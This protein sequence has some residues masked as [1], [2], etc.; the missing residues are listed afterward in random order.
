MTNYTLTVLD[1]SGIQNYLFGTNNLKQNAGASY[2]AD[3][4][5]RDWVKEVLDDVTNGAHNVRGFE[6]VDKPFDESKTI[7]QEGVQAEV[8]YAGGG[9]TVLLFKQVGEAKAFATKLSRKVILEAPDLNL[10]IAHYQD[11]DWESRA[12][13]GDNG[14][15]QSVMN[16]L[17]KRKQEY[18]PPQPLRGLGVTVDGA[19]TNRPAVG[20]DLQNRPVAAESWAKQQAE[21]AAEERLLQFL[22]NSI[23]RKKYSIA[24]D[25]EDIGGS[26]ED[27]SYIAVVHADGN[28]MGKR[29]RAIQ[30]KFPHASQNADYVRAMRVFSLSV[31]G[32]AHTALNTTVD[33]LVGQIDKDFTIGGKIELKKDKDSKPILPFRPIVFGG[34]DVTFICEGRLGLQL[35]AYYLEK[36]TEQLLTDGDEEYGYAYCRAGVAVT[37][38]HYPFALAYELAESLCASAKVAIRRWQEE[39]RKPKEG[40][41]VID[42]HFAING[43]NLGLRE[44]R[45]RDYTS[46][47]KRKST[48]GTSDLLMRPLW[49]EKSPALRLGWHSWEQ[50]ESIL[51]EFQSNWL[52]QRSKLIGLRE[53]LRRGADAVQQYR[54]FYSLQELP[55]ITRHRTFS[56]TGWQGSEC[57]YFDAIEALE[58]YG[59]LKSH[60]NFATESEAG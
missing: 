29:V 13:G 44:T 6:Y 42:W 23:D 24:R 55:P 43:M 38:S 53:P 34:D 8:I 50:F 45:Q 5:T 30:K 3:S 47:A 56:S 21:R 18:P 7:D 4:A 39:E 59:A 14:V 16:Q 40:I 22:D 51:Q 10:L 35:A 58:F 33:F 17:Q 25:F 32:A 31:Q 49:V 20:Y 19:F 9:N 12:L 27:S 2:L 60:K 37:H 28:G 11:F 52:D 57:G 26:H 1:T 15:V 48:Q 36:F 46:D 41:S 54:H